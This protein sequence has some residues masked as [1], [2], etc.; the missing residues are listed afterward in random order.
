MVAEARTCES[1]SQK[2]KG[3]CVSDRNCASVCQTERFPGGHCRGFR[4]RCFCT[5][6]C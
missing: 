1:K 4:R 5:T 6:H 2:F 3:A